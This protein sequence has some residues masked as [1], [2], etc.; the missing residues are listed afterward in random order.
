MAGRE[1]P[2]KVSR[3]AGQPIVRMHPPRT[4]GYFGLSLGGGEAPGCRDGAPGGGL[5]L[6]SL[7]VPPVVL[8]VPR[9]EF[10]ELA[11]RRP[12]DAADDIGGLCCKPA[13]GVSQIRTTTVL[14]SCFCAGQTVL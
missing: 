14:S 4:A 12:G 8:P 11:L 7:I 1:L 13:V 2:A 5:G 3:I 9:K 6:C 10:V